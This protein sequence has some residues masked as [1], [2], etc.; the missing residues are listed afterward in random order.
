MPAAI[1]QHAIVRDLAWA[2]FSEPLVLSPAIGGWQLEPSAFWREHLQT[3]DRDPAPLSEFLADATDGR[4]G[5]YY[6]RLW[7]YLLTQDPD[8][9]LLAHNLPVRAGGR[10]IGEFDCLFWCHASRKPDELVIFDQVVETVTTQQDHISRL[11]LHRLVPNG[12]SEW[13]VS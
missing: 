10:T 8:S 11:E 13:F 5:I 12:R 4:L 3:L 2:G 9:N 1:F 6:E 7:H